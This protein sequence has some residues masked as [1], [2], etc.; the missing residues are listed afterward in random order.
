MTL[1]YIELC[2]NNRDR[3]KWP[4]ESEFQVVYS[5]SG[6]KGRLDA[7]D[8]VSLESSVNAWYFNLFSVSIDMFGVYT[9]LGYLQ[10][11]PLISNLGIGAT[12]DA[13]ATS[14]TIKPI[15]PPGGAC[16]MQYTLGYYNG[17]IITNDRMLA[18]NLPGYRSRINKF[19]YLEQ[20]RAIIELYTPIECLPTDTFTISDP[21]DFSDPLSPQIFV[22][23]G[24]NINNSYSNYYLCNE[25]GTNVKIIGYDGTTHLLLT[26]P[27]I[28]TQTDILSIRSKIPFYLTPLFTSAAIFNSPDVSSRSYSFFN[29]ALGLE[30]VFTDMVGNFLETRTFPN[31]GFMTGGATSF[32]C[33][34]VFPIPVPDNYYVGMR[35]YNLITEEETTIISYDFATNTTTVSPPFSAP[36]GILT[37]FIF[38]PITEIYEARRISK[39]AYYTGTA[40]GGSLTTIEFDNTAS[41]IS[42][43]YNELYIAILNGANANMYFLIK[44]YEATPTGGIA[45]VQS[46]FVAPIVAG[47]QFV[48]NSCVVSPPFPRSI[49]GGI[50][51][52][53]PPPYGFIILN[54]SYDNFFPLDYIGSTLAL[55]QPTCYEIRLEDLSLPNQI[56]DSGNGGII[57]F[58]PYV[59]VELQNVSSSSAGNSNT[60]TSN[61]P[62][63]TKATFRAIIPNVSAPEQQRFVYITSSMTCSL[64]FKPNDT[65]Y[66]KVTLPNGDIFKTITQETYSPLPPNQLTQISALF[67]IRKLT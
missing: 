37:P 14:I 5:N 60:L 47:D 32:T 6:R 15:A 7:I 65:L 13:G 56:L 36:V 34:F 54:F 62:A 52:P 11:Y 45:T 24:L 2:S 1:E 61:N 51:S 63:G 42:G 17:C 35:C 28:F 55:Q 40:T 8:P 46:S 59:Y 66:M 58:Y 38:R 23:N 48:I 67:S 25:T 53:I 30:P 10:V 64:K 26:E 3:N 12:C 44:N 4:E 29:P 31:S 16:Y 39:Y 9:A 41:K 27:G 22:P 57:A 19:T 20:N 33:I 43:T 49:F 50:M 21:S 18:A